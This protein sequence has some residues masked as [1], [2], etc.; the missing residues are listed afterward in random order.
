MRAHESGAGHHATLCVCVLPTPLPGV[1]ISPG[2]STPTIATSPPPQVSPRLRPLLGVRLPCSCSKQ[3]PLPPRL[4]FF[5]GPAVHGRPR[6]PLS[7]VPPKGTSYWR[8][9]I[10]VQRRPT[11]QGKWS[12]CRPR[13]YLSRQTR[14]NS[15]LGT[16]VHSGW[17]LFRVPRP[18]A[19]PSHDLFGSTPCSMY[20]WSSPWSPAPCVRYRLCLL[21]PSSTRGGWS[22]RFGGSSTRAPEDGGCSAWLIGRGMA[23]RSGHGYLGPLLKTPPSSLTLRL[24]DPLLGCQGAS[25]EGGGVMFTSRGECSSP[26]NHLRVNFPQVRS[27]G[28]SSCTESPIRKSGINAGWR[29]HSTP[30][31]CSSLGQLHFIHYPR[32]SN[33]GSPEPRPILLDCP[34]LDSLRCLTHLG[35]PILHRCSPWLPTF[36][37]H[38][39]LLYGQ[40]PYST[41]STGLPSATFVAI[42]K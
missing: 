20:L 31:D 13:I 35:Q 9:C 15:L 36:L 10:V 14:R 21:L 22:T 26:T 41:P 3:V 30:D 12:G 40:T 32:R 34:C 1:T 25:V 39:G 37:A 29:H 18:Y 23:R 42:L 5:V 24:P 28:D 6:D 27:I 11:A 33:P 4:S 16:L 38:H 2:W 17:W 19:S 7:S 8:I